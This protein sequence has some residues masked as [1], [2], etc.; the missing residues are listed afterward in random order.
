MA[1]VHRE[2]LQ[3]V[4]RRAEDD[5]GLGIASGLGRVRRRPGRQPVVRSQ[6]HQVAVAVHRRIAQVAIDIA[7]RADRV[8]LARALAGQVDE[9][10]LAPGQTDVGAHAG[11]A[12]VA[13]GAL[14]ALHRHI[15]TV[16]L[17]FQD[18]VDHPGDRVR[19]VDGRSAVTQYF[20]VVDGRYRNQ[21]QIGPGVAR[22][23]AA[24]G[25]TDVRTGVAALAVHQHQRVTRRQVAQLV[26]AD[27]AFLV[28]LVAADLAERRQAALQGFKQVG[29]AGSRQVLGGNHVDR[30]RAVL[31]RARAGTRTG[32][33]HR[34]QRGRGKVRRSGSGRRRRIGISRIRRGSG[35]GGRNQKGERGQ[36][37]NVGSRHGG[38]WGGPETHLH[39]RAHAP[40][41]T[42][43][44]ASCDRH[45][46]PAT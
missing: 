1:H 8:M 32:H 16:R 39:S 43:D 5:V 9:A 38:S 15:A 36:R 25:A 12:A 44:I 31:H 29:L 27:Q 42:A 13:I 23:A 33:H 17:R 40:R 30:C 7:P 18:H 45:I 2:S 10:I 11:A 35:Q 34:I 6:R 21:R 14:P 41:A 37:R 20:H 46:A 19:T 28:A 24:V 26:A 3:R 22:I 4:R